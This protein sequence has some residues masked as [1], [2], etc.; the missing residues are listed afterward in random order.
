MARRP[1][2][3]PF[4]R[5][6]LL[7]GAAASTLVV[8]AGGLAFPSL[9]QGA[10]VVRLRLLETTDVHV[11]VHP[12][13][14][15]RDRPDDT[16]GLA[17]TAS[18]IQTARAGAANSILVDNGDF[19]QGNPM[20]DYM[21]Y[22]RGLEDGDMHPIITAMN[23][24]G[25]DVA[26]LGNHEFNYGL[27][28]LDKALAGA[29]FPLVSANVVRE[30]G[31]DPTADTTLIPPYVILERDLVDDAG[32]T[33]TVKIA[34]IGFVPPQIMTWDRSHLEGNVTTRDIVDTAAA[35]V[36]VL[37][38]QADLV[39]ALSHSGIDAG[40][41]SGGEENASLHLAGVDGIDAIFTGHQHRVFPG[42]TYE[43]LEGVDAVDG[44]LLG[45]PA[46]MAGYWGSHLGQIDL[47]LARD[48]GRWRVLDHGVDNLP[49][50]ERVERQVTPLVDG[51]PAV[52]ASVEAEHQATIAYVNRAVG[53]ISAPVNSYFA[54]VADDPSVQIVSQAQ[55]W[56]VEQMM[57]GTQWAGL[58]ILSAAA[59]F[60]A[61]GRGGPDYY[62]VVPAGPIAIRNVADLYLYPNTIRA[63]EIDGATV[64]EWLERSAGIFNQVT[65]G[66][67]DQPL[68]NPEFPSFNFDVI[69]GV[70]YEIDLSQ[71]SR[72]DVD[73]NLVAPDARRIVNLAFQGSP[74]DDAQRFVV[75]TNNYRAGG[76]GNFP[77]A[78]GSTTIFEGPDTNRDIIVRYIV[79]Q[80]TINPSADANWRFAP[81]APGT[82]VLFESGP[83][84]A[85]F[86]GTV[87]GVAPAGDGENGFAL[88]R[89]TLGS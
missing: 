47:T 60:K 39:I 57:A 59:P 25:F 51:V 86:A 87:P 7:R 89:M 82:T 16:V 10:G 18:L 6:S 88:Y 27:S 46:A 50:Y 73:G 52:L 1:L 48:G 54:L 74:I 22:E 32:E 42:P 34:F 8:G 4:S 5:R 13:D 45:V 44:A 65:P 49:I 14:Y 20:G 64:R 40:S 84:A 26:T 21:A 76:G 63:V 12:Y 43:G 36:P 38:E 85:E 24:V 30:Q 9:A 56:Y 55:T 75:A 2:D 19:L 81:M 11:F 71:P 77:G 61:G 66:Q 68:L 67:P 79:E 80:G 17:R 62:T 35:Y 31:A 70:T 3:K 58:P 41:R 15:Y 69:D 37:R 28:F 72:Y 53:Q 23:A 83:G 29:D 78:D 33:H